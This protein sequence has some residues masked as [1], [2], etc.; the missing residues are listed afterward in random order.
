MRPYVRPSLRPSLRL[1]LGLAISTALALPSVA[2]S[3]A[4]KLTYERK[5]SD[6][7]HTSTM[8]FDGERIRMDGMGG[9]RRGAG[10]AGGGGENHAVIVDAAAK[11][12]I[13]LNPE[14]KTYR[15][16]TE[17][18]TK[19]MKERMAGAQAQMAE[20]MKDMPPEQRKRAEEMMARFGGGP[21]GA[22]MQIKYEPL[23]T[24]KK[25]NGFAC[26]MYRVTMNGRPSSESCIAPWS[27]NI[28]SKAETEKWKKLQAELAKSF[29]MMPGFRNDQ[30][31]APGIPVEQ[32]H[33]GPDGKTAEWTSV[34]KSISRDPVPAST[35]EIPAGFTKLDSFTNGPRGPQRPHDTGPGP[36]PGAGP[37]P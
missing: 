23:G 24:K 22:G 16:L 35:F 21:G 36:V 30:L 27:S 31:S 1:S 2:A 13:M 33:L 37:P 32:T 20:R 5:T 3:A 12:I 9:G 34:L 10:G 29:D 6:G 8:T 25:V 7:A 28:V 14:Q 4:V 18:D 26:E 17:A 11:K 19:R 15:E